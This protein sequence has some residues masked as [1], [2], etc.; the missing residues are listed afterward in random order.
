MF[1]VN[2]YCF[3][4]QSQV[5][6]RIPVCCVIFILDGASKILPKIKTKSELFPRIFDEFDVFVI[7][8]F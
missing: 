4:L 2:L 1:L 3:K 7:I 8:N 6:V 5:F